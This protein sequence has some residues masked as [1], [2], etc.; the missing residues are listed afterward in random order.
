MSTDRSDATDDEK[1]IQLIDNHRS[2]ANAPI[3][4][5]LKTRLDSGVLIRVKGEFRAAAL[6]IS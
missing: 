1:R 3:A 2:V 5:F 6:K 4:A